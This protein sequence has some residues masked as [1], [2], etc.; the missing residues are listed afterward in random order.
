MATL[1]TQP[2]E[3]IHQIMDETRPD[4]IWSFVRCCKK[5]WIV[6][7]EKLQQHKQDIDRY[8]APQSCFWHERP[9]LNLTYEFISEVWHQ[10]HRA[11]YVNELDSLGYWQTSEL[12]RRHVFTTSTMKGIDDV[13][14]LFFDVVGSPYF[15]G[16]EVGEW[17]AKLR[18]CD[19]NVVT[20]LFLTLLPNLKTLTILQ[21][22]DEVFAD[23]IYKVSKVNQSSQGNNP[24][25]LP[26]NKLDTI[27]IRDMR[28]T[29]RP[30]NRLGI[31]EV[32]MTL[33]SLRKLKGTYIDWRFDRWP[34]EEDFQRESN[35]NEIAFVNSAVNAEAFTRLLTE[36]KNLQLFT[37]QFSRLVGIHGDHTAMSLKKV[38]E[39][40]A[41]RTLTHLD[42]DFNNALD[43]AG[44]YI[45]SLRQ[46]E[47]LKDL[48][49]HANMLI[50]YSQL[51]DLHLLVDLIPLLPA[52][53]ETLTLLNRAE[54]LLATFTLL[55]LHEKREECIPHLKEFV[56]GSTIS[57]HEGLTEECADVGIV[58]TQP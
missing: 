28:I 10:P 46:L 43:D 40:Y 48:H 26:L 50:D 29:N 15:H 25:A 2:N 12:Y 42:L 18:R 58:L 30:N 55:E 4:S 1:L 6:G 14:S 20:C 34:S 51:G 22:D 35:V 39:Q 54:D 38:L 45:G 32:C 3:I 36:T 7:A 16:D 37:Y 17:R 9:G 57:I 41:A 8:R 47:V 53:I 56:C 5:I 27:T 33:P 23:L 13:C 52:S 21:Y 31:Y 24:E 19:T 44:R 49:I 11:L